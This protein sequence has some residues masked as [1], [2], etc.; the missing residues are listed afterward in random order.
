M[1]KLIKKLQYALVAVFFAAASLAVIVPPAEVAANGPR[2]CDSNAVMRC[3]ALSEAELIQKYRANQ[4]GN[5][6]AIFSHFGINSEAELM[7]MVEGSI[8]GSNQV[9]VGDRLVATDAY[10]AGRQRI[11]RRGGVSTPIVNGAAFMRQPSVSFRDAR[12]SLSTFV[13]L[14]QHG[15]FLYAVIKSCGNPVTAKPVRQP[16]P[17]TPVV[18]P[19]K[20]DFNVEK[21]VRNIDSTD[22]KEQADAKPGDRLEYRITINNTGETELENIMVRDSLPDGLE[23]QT[24]SLEIPG[25]G[26]A[27]DFF[28]EGVNIGNLEPGQSVQIT[29]IVEV[30]QRVEACRDRA[31][32]NIVYVTP[33]ELPTKQDRA[34]VKVCKPPETVKVVV[35]KPKKEKE[36]EK[37]VPVSLP[38]TGPGAAFGAFF[39]TTLAGAAAHRLIYR[40]LK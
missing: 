14:D 13:K 3:G 35:E 34:F 10:T 33:D 2:D 29:I 22:W 26:S 17:V 39:S 27:N 38:V 5:T 24:G 25:D 12:S 32:R 16:E 23:Y 30:A 18:E 8:N 36:V 11:D 6:Q 15:N 4:A 21:V 7:G 9:F 31:L 19:E 20:P 37:P 1:R 28:D 40:R